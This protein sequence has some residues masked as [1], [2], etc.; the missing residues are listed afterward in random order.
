[1]VHSFFIFRFY[2]SEAGEGFKG[3]ECGLWMYCLF[4]TFQDRV[5]IPGEREPEVQKG[6]GVGFVQKT[7][8][9]CRSRDKVVRTSS[10]PR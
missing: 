4:L 7:T 2:V 3:L 10:V 9:Q 1:M 6:L 8:K 5:C